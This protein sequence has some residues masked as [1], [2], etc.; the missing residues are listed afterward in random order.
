MR[1]ALI[2]S[3]VFLCSGCLSIHVYPVVPAT[4][5]GQLIGADANAPMRDALRQEEHR[6]NAQRVEIANA[7]ARTNV[8][9][10]TDVLRWVE[11]PSAFGGGNG[12]FGGVSFQSMGYDVT[13][14]QIYTTMDGTFMLHA[15]DHQVEIVGEHYE[16]GLRVVTVVVG[17]GPENIVTTVT[18]L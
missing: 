18:S 7:L 4:V 16:Q 13:N 9:I 11:K 5:E 1:F 15:S 3:V 6:L 2:A 8:A 14:G 10:A 17:R 12:W